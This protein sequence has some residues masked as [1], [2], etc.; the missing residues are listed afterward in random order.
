MLAVLDDLIAQS[1]ASAAAYE[2]FLKQAEELARRLV[3]KHPSGDV[4]AAFRGRY[5][6]SRRYTIK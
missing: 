2:Q 3:K 4:P 1:R 6:W 5:C